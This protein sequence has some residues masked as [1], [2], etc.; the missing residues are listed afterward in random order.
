MSTWF[1]PPT[2]KQYFAD[3]GQDRLMSRVP[4]DVGLAVVDNGGML[5]PF[6]GKQVVVQDEFEAATHVYMGGFVNGPLSAPEIANLVAA[7]YGPNPGPYLSTT[8]P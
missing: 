1:R 4:F 6:P 5:T 7:G 8:P 3:P 2:Y